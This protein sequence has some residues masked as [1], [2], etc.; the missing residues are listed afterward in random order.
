M[1]GRRKNKSQIGDSKVIDLD[2]LITTMGQSIDAW[3]FQEHPKL[4]CR[5]KF[6]DICRDCSLVPVSGSVFSSEWDRFDEQATKRFGLA[7]SGFRIEAPLFALQENSDAK[8]GLQK[9]SSLATEHD[10]LTLDV[11]VRSDVRLEELARHFCAKWQL[12]IAN[13]TPEASA[14]RLYD[15]DFGRLMREANDAKTS[16]KDRMAYL[17]ELQK[18]QE[19]SRRPR[20]G[21]W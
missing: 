12:P 3:R 1:F 21:K 17:K 13:E 7:L 10:Q 4:L 8:V 14:N 2:E 16:A 5:A 20:R 19:E 18:E 9:V 15:I 6:A 11:L